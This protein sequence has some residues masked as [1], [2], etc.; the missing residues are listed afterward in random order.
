MKPLFQ[1]A[2]IIGKGIDYAE[3]AKQTTTR[4][5]PGYVLSR[6][7]LME[8]AKCP[9]R[10]RLGYAD[11]DDTKSTEWGQLL[12][13][14]LLDKAHIFKRIA[15]TPLEYPAKPAKK[16]DPIEDKPW[17][18]NATYCKDWREKQGD[19]LVVAQKHFTEAEDAVQRLMDDKC[20]ASLISASDSQ[21]MVTGEYH[22]D[23]TALVV[24]CR[25]LI[26]LHPSDPKSNFDDALADLKTCASAEPRPWARAVFQR[27]YH[28]QAALYLDLFNCATGEDRREF[29]HVLQ[30]NVK[31]FETA[32]RSLS[33]EFISIGRDF[34]RNALVRYCQCLK[35]GTWPGYDD[36]SSAF[37]W[38][39][40]DVEPWMVMS[41]A[42]EAWRSGESVNDKLDRV[43]L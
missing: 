26:D 21:V 27:G 42:S 33:A 11:D 34:Y 41:Q 23:A 2:E 6:G 10:W 29:L 14:I 5:E 19:K 9:R 4:G 12:E 38:Q 13:I 35:S 3:Y 22:D 30:E 15:V 16:G 7:D 39:V 25:G 36:E 17:N 1:N 24:P 28:V 32:R 18:W 31:P 40:V 20:I 8:F 43:G 37:P